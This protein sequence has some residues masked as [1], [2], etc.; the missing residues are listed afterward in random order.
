ME[1]ISTISYKMKNA[2]RTGA[3]FPCNNSVS[4][5]CARESREIMGI[6]CISRDFEMNYGTKTA[7]EKGAAP[8]VRHLLGLRL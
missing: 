7:A 6:F 2:G 3:E 8:T 5:L 4:A 1:V